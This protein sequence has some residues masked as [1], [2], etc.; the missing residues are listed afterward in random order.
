MTTTIPWADGHVGDGAAAG[1]TLRRSLRGV[2][3]TL[4]APFFVRPAD[5]SASSG[6]HVDQRQNHTDDA[7]DDENQADR[8]PRYARHVKRHAVADDRADRDKEYRRAERH[9]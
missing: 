3:T 4:E 5:C 6:G 2:T 8:W 1:P 9:A 7:G